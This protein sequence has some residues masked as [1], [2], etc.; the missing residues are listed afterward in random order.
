MAKTIQIVLR[1][2]LLY[3]LL[4]DLRVVRTCQVC[5]QHGSVCI[6][7]ASVNWNRDRHFMGNHMAETEDFSY[8]V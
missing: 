6:D 4:S 1:M 3:D 8:E 2:G 7:S 5:I